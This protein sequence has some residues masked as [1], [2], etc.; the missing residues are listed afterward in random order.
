M[1]IDN[2]NYEIGNKATANILLLYYHILNEKGI[3]HSQ[4]VYIDE[5]EFNGFD[6][7]DVQVIE[8][9]KECLEIDERLLKEG[10]IIYLICELNDIV[11]EYEEDFH[12]KELTKKI[13]KVLETHKDYPI[14][15]ISLLLEQIMVVESEV[16]WSTYNK[17][18]DIIYKKYIEGLFLRKIIPNYDKDVKLIKNDA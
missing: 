2:T 9:E 3:T 7:I 14:S 8:Q 16:D 17:I 5:K 12:S 15:E 18:L 1:I 4:T 10:S 13:C 11:S 6:F